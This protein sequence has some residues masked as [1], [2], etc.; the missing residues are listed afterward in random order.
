MTYIDYIIIVIVLVGFL[1]GFKDGLVRK[2]IG[3][4]G[5]ILGVFFAIEFS[6]E[7]GSFLIP[8][9]NDEIYFA[10][11]VSG[12]IIFFLTIFIASIV[13]RII[14]PLDKV[15]KFVN[16]LLG[17]I[18]G[19]IQI[20]VFISGFFLFLSIF[21]FPDKSTKEESLLYNG[22]AGIV[23]GAIDFVLGDHSKTKIYLQ[24]YIE[25][26]QDITPGDTNQLPGDTELSE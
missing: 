5:L 14:H 9:F 12:F 10:N 11:I 23:P 17:G 2:I 16:Q 6:S 8:I 22:I 13:K 7:V 21:N 4:I 3:L 25:G 20:I 1:L 18:T 15:N 26:N 24:N 19:A